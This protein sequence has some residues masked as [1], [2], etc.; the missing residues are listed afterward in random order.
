MF[1]E[2]ERLKKYS[3]SGYYY[4]P[5]ELYDLLW[6]DEAGKWTMNASARNMRS[7]M[8]LDKVPEELD[9]K[10]FEIILGE[11]EIECYDYELEQI[12]YM[13]PLEIKRSKSIE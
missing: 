10:G 8:D 2:T 12:R 6:S 5:T 9:E 1:E 11:F 13:N 4:I 3:R 7:C